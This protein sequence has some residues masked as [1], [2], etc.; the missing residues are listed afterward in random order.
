M[1]EANER[2]TQLLVARRIADK[3]TA[4]LTARSF[5]THFRNRDERRTRL[6]RLTYFPILELL[7]YRLRL[8]GIRGF[9]RNDSED[10]AAAVLDG[11]R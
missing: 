1:N 6:K 7:S 9:S 10:A 4:P 3:F 2:T 11:G 8:R 5:P